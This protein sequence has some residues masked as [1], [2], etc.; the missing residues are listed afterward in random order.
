[1]LQLGPVRD[2]DPVVGGINFRFDPAIKGSEAY[3][4]TVSR[5]GIDIAARKP[6]GFFYAVQ[7][8][9][10][11]LPAEVER[12]H[13]AEWSIPAVAI[14]D[15]PRFPWRGMH[16]D[17]SRHFFTVEQVKRYLDL[18]ALHKLNVFHWHLVDD[19]GWRIEIKQYPKLTSLGGF[20]AE[21]KQWNQRE[22]RY[23][24]SEPQYGGFYTQAEI[25]DVVRYAQARAI[26]IVPEIEMPGHTMPVIAAYP[27]LACPNYDRKGFADRTGNA[28]SNVYCAGKEQSFQFIENVLSEVIQ[29]F[30]S[31]FI[32]VGGDEVDKYLWSKCPACKAR[33]AQ[34]G[35][36]DE[37]ELQSYFIRRIE[38][39]L[40][41]KGRRLIG[42]DEILEGGLA[43]NAA[44]MSWR[45]ISGGIAAARAG[46]DV[47]MSPTSPCYFDYGYDS[48][49]VEAVY[50]WNP[51][52][53]ELK[54]N[55]ADRVLG[56]Q[57]NVWTEWIPNFRRVERMTFPRILSLA[58]VLWSSPEGRSYPEFE[59][60]LG[61]YWP[62][63][64]ALDI[65]AFIP[66]PT[67]DETL[68]F[69]DGST[70]WTPPSNPYPALT[71]R[72]TLDGSR[73]TKNSSALQGP[74]RIVNPTTLRLAYFDSAGLSGD[75]ASVSFIA[76]PK[77]QTGAMAVGL[78]RE[79]FEGKFDALPD[80]SK[81]KP[82]AT[83]LAQGF[84]ASDLVGKGASYACRFSGFLAI[85]TDG[86]YTFELTSD[87][88]SR[89]LLAG[90]VL[91]SNDGLHA[92]LAKRGKVRLRAG[93]YSIEAAFFN[94]LGADVFNLRVAKDDGP[95][96]P[97]PPEW[98][99]RPNPAR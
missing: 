71:C 38:K 98:I 16:L 40:N 90:S 65:Q 12:K 42:W 26:T 61:A 9:R 2:S 7:T 97:I 95:M 18:M 15:S 25:K 8:L 63:L 85:P 46:H 77:G 3:T 27:E 43:P 64:S 68:V 45:G 86:V 91:I 41:S 39:Y 92:A 34:E 32:H 31:E 93:V 73:P 36:K 58:E 11:C 49:S 52:P 55:G 22:L 67:L 89:L 30:P 17:V 44:V 10:Q 54:P 28:I 62:R 5:T 4:L 21:T 84:D 81:L 14:Q 37:Q 60:R 82:K 19:G 48:N 29:L 99:R 6:A 79:V 35:L 23:G 47:V 78:V 20:R 83:A 70:L 53:E 24:T 88:G 13:R 59:A 56:G 51:I 76:T 50:G 87:D 94:G 96:G 74:V 1:M 33:M 57:G 80:F 72:Y 66:A 75:A 69:V